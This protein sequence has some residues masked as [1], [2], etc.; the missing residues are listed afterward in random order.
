MQPK[1]KDAQMFL[2]GFKTLQ[3]RKKSCSSWERH[4][5]F[6]LLKLRDESD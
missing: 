5:K 4:A 3:E 6:A 2:Y 1:A